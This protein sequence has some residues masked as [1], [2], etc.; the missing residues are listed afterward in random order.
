MKILVERHNTNKKATLSDIFVFAD[1]ID[2]PIYKCAGLEDPIRAQ[3]I[4]TISCIPAG[5][6]E[7]KVRTFGG[8]HKKYEQKLPFHQG[9]LEIADVPNFTDILIHIG[10]FPQ[11][12]SGCLL[13]GQNFKDYTAI[14]NSKDTYEQLYK[15]VIDAALDDN[16]SIEFVNSE[17]M[18][19]EN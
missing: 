16:L 3:K 15:L 14:Y 10:N 7:V 17:N 9:M 5:K 19:Y 18:T 2:L 1:E 11:D 13:V 8:F 6:Y 12:T 4:P